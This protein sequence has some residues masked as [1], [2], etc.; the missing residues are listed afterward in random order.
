MKTF[1]IIDD[2]SSYQRRAP[3]FEM[4]NEKTIQINEC[5]ACHRCNKI[6]AGTVELHIIQ[7]K[8]SIWPDFLEHYNNYKGLFVSE[9]VKN[10]LQSNNIAYEY[11]RPVIIKPPFPKKLA[12]KPM[13]KYFWIKPFW[14]G[15]VD[16][17]KSEVKIERTCTVCGRKW[18]YNGF[19]DNKKYIKESSWKGYDLFYT[20]N[21]V[22]VFCTAKVAKL[23]LKE[24]W[25]NAKIYPSDIGSS[26]KNYGI[27]CFE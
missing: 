26:Y 7:K 22:Y 4:D 11:E 23:A 1:Y 19:G 3:R 20:A 12:D 24:K 10:D 9:R 14:G 21:T 6:H 2:N 13:P 8:G 16:E 25:T 15:E 5:P 17:D 27:L 18:Y